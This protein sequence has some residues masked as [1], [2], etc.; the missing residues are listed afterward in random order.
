MAQQSHS[1][2]TLK[3]GVGGSCCSSNYIYKRSLNTTTTTTDQVKNLKSLDR[4]EK[5]ISPSEFQ[6][7]LGILNIIDGTVRQDVVDQI[8]GRLVN[9]Q[10]TGYGQIYNVIGFLQKLRAAT[11]QGT[12]AMDSNG[13]MIQ[14]ARQAQSAQKK[15]V[16]RAKHSAPQPPKNTVSPQVSQRGMEAL[17]A[18]KAQMKIN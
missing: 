18:L 8:T 16:E 3:N 2:P 1:L 17:S 4:L 9:Y 5:L 14:N 13:L 11:E 6:I 7:T 15:A 12:F 10:K